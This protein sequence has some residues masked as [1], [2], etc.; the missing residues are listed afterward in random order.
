MAGVRILVECS[1]RAF[2]LAVIKEDSDDGFINV[3]NRVLNIRDCNDKNEDF[4]TCKEIWNSTYIKSFEAISD[5]Y[6]LDLTRD[7]KRNINNTVKEVDLNMFVHN[8]RS[9]STEMAVQNTMRIFA[10]LLNYITDVLVFTNS[11]NQ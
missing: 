9:L 2:I 3:V 6:R 7:V 4:K 10:P 1:C 8:P 11:V 5:S